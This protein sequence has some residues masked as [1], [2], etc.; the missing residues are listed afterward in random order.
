MSIK[1]TTLDNGLR[2][3]T[4]TVPAVES[5]AVGF[6]ADVGARHEVAA[7]NGVAHMVEHMMFKGTPTRDAAQIAEQIENV[8]GQ[9]N[10]Y[11]SRE[12]TSYHV[13]LLK[14]DTDLALDVLS[15]IIQNPTM[16]D[17]EIERERGVILQEIGMSLDT[18]DDLVFDQYQE[19]AYKGQ[20][21]GAPILG[22]SD[23]ISN[24]SRDT[25]MAHVERF[26]TP[27]RL[28]LA[29]SGNLDHDYIVSKAEALLGNLPVNEGRDA[30]KAEYSGG[31]IR[32]SK[33]L[34]QSHIILG[35][36]GLSR[37]DDDFYAVMVMGT[38]LGGG[39]STRLFQE[40]REK[41][42]LVYTVFAHHSPYQDAGQMLIYAGTGPEKLPELIPVL[43]DEIMA[44]QNNIT[45][46]EFAR[47][48]AQIKADMVMGQESMMRR[49]NQMGKH[50]IHYGEV[51]D[52]QQKLAKLDSLTI[53]DLQ[54]A[55]KRVFSTKPTLAG[56]GPL[57][58]LESYDKI[59][60]RLAA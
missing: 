40:I 26:Y 34:E 4:D 29:A 43:C 37:H 14:E 53:E 54:R 60:E 15:D 42:G 13:H 10:A 27:Q 44:I 17:D 59:S 30:A 9:M 1:L 24:M 16:P 50:L 7:E 32:V 48:K 35:F 55:A 45:A 51:P 38:A 56:L 47:A 23:I 28:V 22:T 31:E 41:R 19:T 3:I 25:L 36:D 12:I 11:T 21:L 20:A 46:E 33:D 6:W 8:G 5:I 49:T 39:M 2:V 57:G 52:L 58:Q 18:P